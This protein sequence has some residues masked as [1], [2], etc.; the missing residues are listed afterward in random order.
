MEAI[1]RRQATTTTTT[2]QFGDRLLRVVTK[3]LKCQICQRE[4]LVAGHQRRL[5]IIEIDRILMALWTLV[6]APLRIVEL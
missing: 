1:F 4:T 5:T 6:N 2:L 3:S